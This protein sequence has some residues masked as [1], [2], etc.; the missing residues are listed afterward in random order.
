MA[1]TNVPATAMPTTPDRG[2][3]ALPH[4]ATLPEV[5]RT[6]GGE[7]ASWR[8]RKPKRPQSIQQA[9]EKHAA[10]PAAFTSPNATRGPRR[11]EA[12]VV[13]RYRPS[14]RPRAWG[15]AASET[16][17]VA[18]DQKE[19]R[20]TACTQ[21]TKSICQNS[22]HSGN[23]TPPSTNDARPTSMT[24]FVPHRSAAGPKAKRKRTAAAR[25]TLF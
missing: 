1:A 24:G 11:S 18:D 5:A 25:Y 12:E 8:Q 4:R 7:G 2:K 6:D 22:A 9:L 3:R 14:Q 16:V 19:A 23:R 10:N 17:A 13:R 15:G 21:R 20:P